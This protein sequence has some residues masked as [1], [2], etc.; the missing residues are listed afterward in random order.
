MELPLLH[1]F[2]G[3]FKG[4]HIVF[5]NSAGEFSHDGFLNGI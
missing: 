2:M 4:G 3:P 1:D 5:A